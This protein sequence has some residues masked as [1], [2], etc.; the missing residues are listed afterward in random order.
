M[1]DI[2]SEGEYTVPVIPPRGMKGY[3]MEQCCCNKKTVRSDEEKRTISSRVNR[4]VGQLG[5][6]KRMV[7]EDRYCDDILIQL[8]AVDKAVRSL[9]A[10]LLERHLHTCVI[11]NVKAGNEDVVDEVV[12]LFRRF[13]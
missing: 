6:I 13:E 9:A 4:I 2:S 3:A 10:F 11:E 5:G 7:D 8:S 1:L 12:E